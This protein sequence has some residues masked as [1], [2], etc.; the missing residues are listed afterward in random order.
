MDNPDAQNLV[1]PAAG[2]H[3]M[4]PAHFSPDKMGLIVPKTSD[5]RCVGWTINGDDKD[6]NNNNNNKCCCSGSTRRLR[7]TA[8]ARRACRQQ[9]VPHEP[10]L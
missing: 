5:G 10:N 6:H 1:V 2:V 9:A 8:T 7:R 3:I 4:L